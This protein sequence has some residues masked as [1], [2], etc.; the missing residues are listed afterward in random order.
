MRRPSEDLLLRIQ[1]EYLEMPGL[2]LTPPQ[3]Q[4]LW[5]LYRSECEMLMS[6][7]VDARFLARTDDGSYV[8]LDVNSPVSRGGGRGGWPAASR[9]GADS[10]HR[11]LPC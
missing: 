9:S 4:R 5:G 2:R 6:V 11:V 1:G 8:R 3:A 10:Y 7:L